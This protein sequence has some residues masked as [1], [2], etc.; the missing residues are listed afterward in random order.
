MKN[1]QLFMTLI[2]AACTGIMLHAQP[3][4]R[5]DER[6]ELSGIA[7]YLAGYPEYSMCQ[8]S[9]Y[10]DAVDSCFRDCTDHDLI[11]F[12]RQLRETRGTGFDAVTTAASMLVIENGS[13]GLSPL[14]DTSMLYKADRRWS[15][16]VFS[17]YVSLLDRFYRDTD[18]GSFYSS[19][20]DLYAAG[21]ELV[22]ANIRIDT[23]WFRLFY[24][25][26]FGHP[27]L[28]V[29]FING[30]SNYALPDRGIIPGYGIVAGM[31]LDV[32]DRSQ[33]LIFEQAKKSDMS[34]TIIHEL[35]HNFTNPDY[36]G[37]REDFSKSSLRLFKKKY[38]REKMHAAAYGD[39]DIMAVEWLNSLCTAMYYRDHGLL[40]PDSGEKESW[41]ISWLVSNKE[42]IR[43]GFFWLG[44]SISLMED[45]YADR[46]RYP[47][48]RDFL[49]ELSEYYGNLSRHYRKEA[50]RFMSYF[51][52][53]I[54]SEVDS[55]SDRD[56]LFIRV[57]FSHPMRT[58]QHGTLRHP[59]ERLAVLQTDS[60]KDARF[61]DP[62][63]YVISKSVN[64]LERG[65]RYGLGIPSYVFQSEWGFPLLENYM[66]EFKMY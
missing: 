54:S 25:R 22:N 45:F 62:E 66:I 52:E 44:S 40:R 53:I 35:C 58:Y 21:E 49:P 19:F 3:S 55:L 10:R 60:R 65:V 7:A 34:F 2:C 64:E 51:P 59:D 38:V 28:Y 5:T 15:A 61:T 31:P 26:E 17:K 41:R 16:E 24:G 18:F 20:A 29:S 6:F 13:V 43:K 32:E 48:F 9:S 39:P 8:V 50:R 42:M 47:Y 11:K 36:Y 46:E 63:T 23:A 12:M 37:C 57:T 33:V 56:S 27:E 30:P 1:T 4:F 14:A